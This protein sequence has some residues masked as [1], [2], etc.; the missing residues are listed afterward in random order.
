MA[1]RAGNRRQVDAVNEAINSVLDG[2]IT[3]SEALT[4]AKVELSR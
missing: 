3:A 4:T 2:R 1:A